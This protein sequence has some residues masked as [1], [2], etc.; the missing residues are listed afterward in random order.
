M[1]T[2][3]KEKSQERNLEILIT[4]YNVIQFLIYCISY[5]NKLC[6]D[7]CFGILFSKLLYQTVIEQ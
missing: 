2:A 5:F 1:L 4:V 7:D 6:C 3:L